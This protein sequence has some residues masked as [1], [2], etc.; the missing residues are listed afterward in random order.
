MIKKKFFKWFT[1]PKSGFKAAHQ[2]NNN[3]NSTSRK[4][5][6]TETFKKCLQQHGTWPPS[7]VYYSV[8]CLLFSCTETAGYMAVSVRISSNSRYIYCCLLQFQEDIYNVG[9]DWTR[10]QLGLGKWPHACGRN[11]KEGATVSN[12]ATLA[13]RPPSL[14]RH[15]NSERDPT[16][17]RTWLS[18][19]MPRWI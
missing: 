7:P 2:K 8:C 19:T 11:I 17:K 1:T 14:R 6:K 10:Q 13:S 15:N 3:R 16:F 9:R 12:I 18:D 4:G 5:K